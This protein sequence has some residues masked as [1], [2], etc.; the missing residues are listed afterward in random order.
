MGN[1][2]T[3]GT[4]DVAQSNHTRR[5]FFLLLGAADGLHPC[6]HVHHDND[7]EPDINMATNEIQLVREKASKAKVYMCIYIHEYDYD[8]NSNQ[9]S[10]RTYPSTKTMTTLGRQ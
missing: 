7:D 6:I 2:H 10:G 1:S 4:F 8:S 9:H 3:G 5:I